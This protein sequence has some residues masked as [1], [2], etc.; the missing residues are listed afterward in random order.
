MKLWYEKYFRSERGK[1]MSEKYYVMRLLD[2]ALTGYCLDSTM[3]VGT[4]E[5]IRAVI[6]TMESYGIKDGT[7]DAVRRYLSGDKNVMRRVA[8][9]DIPALEECKFIS[10]A[11]FEVGNKEWNYTSPGG[12]P[13]HIRCDRAR[14]KQ[15]LIQHKGMYY[16]LSRNWYDNLCY[17]SPVGGNGVFGQMYNGPTYL[18]DVTQLDD[19]VI[20]INNRLYVLEVI[21]ENATLGRTMQREDD[22]R[23]YSFCDDIVKMSFPDRQRRMQEL[24]TRI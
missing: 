2:Y 18:Y 7:V 4:E 21:S 10:S 6:S 16:R 11:A 3:Y 1:E 23:P 13:Y 9:E 15:I 24:Y 17:E 22:L 8:G 19:G 14:I 20:R 5:E 12:T